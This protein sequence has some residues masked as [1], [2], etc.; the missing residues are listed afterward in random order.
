MNTSNLQVS[1]ELEQQ[2]LAVTA[3]SHLIVVE[4]KDSYDF[5]MGF[6]KNIKSVMKNIEN[7]WSDPKKKANEAWK[8]IV[9]KEKEMLAPLSD[10]EVV[11]KKK[12]T[13]YAEEQRRI[14]AEIQAKLEVERRKQADEL[15]K[16]AAAA[17]K[18]GNEIQAQAIMTLAEVIE[19]PPISAENTKQS[20][21]RQ[22]KRLRI[23]DQ[24][25]VPAYIEG[26]CLRPVDMQCVSD[27]YKLSGKLPAGI[28]EYT[29]TIISVR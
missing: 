20:G 22:I 4:D 5:A 29:D 19:T 1:K 28:E 24:L 2:Q 9:A 17:E 6:L 15:M 26:F 13:V 10:A 3:Q 21:T 11:I 8:A 18:E 16:Q 23:I 7:Y 14:E 12:M 25:K 27:Y